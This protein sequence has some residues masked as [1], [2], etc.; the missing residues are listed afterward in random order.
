MIE[1]RCHST[2]NLRLPG[3][4]CNSKNTPPLLPDE[5]S[6]H[7]G[8]NLGVL[9]VEMNVLVNSPVVATAPNFI[10]PFVLAENCEYPALSKMKLNPIGITV[11]NPSSN[12]EP[13][14]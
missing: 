13:T 10:N 7:I 9:V 11:E 5:P 4:P 3:D 6:S 14:I 1:V 12:P 2:I 8:N